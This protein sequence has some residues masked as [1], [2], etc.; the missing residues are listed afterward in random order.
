[1]FILQ[2]YNPTI[3]LDYF[4]HNMPNKSNH[5]MTK[6]H[7]FDN[8]LRTAN[9]WPKFMLVKSKPNLPNPF[10]IDI[11]QNLNFFFFSFLESGAGGWFLFFPMQRR[12][13]DL[14]RVQSTRDNN[15]K[16]IPNQKEKFG[17]H[18]KRPLL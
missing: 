15:I 13:I 1:M 18:I 6:S 11:K 2:V 14:E 7:K 3:D 17:N 16:V 12:Y 4:D 8:P 10:I 9:L 5:Q